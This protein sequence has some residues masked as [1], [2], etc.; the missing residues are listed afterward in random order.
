MM[1][2]KYGWHRCRGR[3]E[4]WLYTDYTTGRQIFL[5]VEFIGGERTRILEVRG[6]PNEG[7]SGVLFECDADSGYLAFEF[8]RKSIHPN[9]RLYH[10]IPYK[11]VYIPY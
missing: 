7:K 3:R 5:V 11:G 8:V 9:N 4:R 10:T 6:N 1:A 2:K